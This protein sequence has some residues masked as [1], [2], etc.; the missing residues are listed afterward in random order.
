MRISGL[1]SV[2]FYSATQYEEEGEKKMSNKWINVSEWCCNHV[3]DYENFVSAIETEKKNHFV[4]HWI[5]LIFL[6]MNLPFILWLIDW[7]YQLWKHD[8]VDHDYDDDDDDLNWIREKKR[9]RESGNFFFRL[10]MI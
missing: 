2:F 4:D 6:Y 3:M 5:N 8:H 9:E 10:I 1:V 7:F